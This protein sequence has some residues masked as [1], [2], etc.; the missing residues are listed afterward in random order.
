MCFRELEDLWNPSGWEIAFPETK[1]V[2]E[3]VMA[4]LMYPVFFVKYHSNFK[5]GRIW[6]CMSAVFF[7]L[8][9]SFLS[10]ALVNY[11]TQDNNSQYYF[12]ESIRG[13]NKTSNSNLI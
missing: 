6:F 11:H 3:K 1:N 2:I 10:A 7:I 8:F 5:N 13:K 4:Y 9:V 12:A